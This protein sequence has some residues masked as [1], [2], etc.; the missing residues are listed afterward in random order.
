MTDQPKKFVLL[1]IP[2]SGLFYDGGQFFDGYQDRINWDRTLP[3]YDTASEAEEAKQRIMARYPRA[4][5]EL[6]TMGVT[7]IEGVV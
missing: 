3:L 6:V 2:K 1:W 7:T 4:K 5:G